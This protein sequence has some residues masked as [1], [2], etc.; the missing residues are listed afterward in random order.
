MEPKERLVTVARFSDAI[1]AQLTKGGLEAEGIQCSLADLAPD[2]PGFEIELQVRESDVGRA[3]KI[4]SERLGEEEL[5]GLPSPAYSRRYRTYA[6]V[7]LVLSAIL[8]L[9]VLFVFLKDL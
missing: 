8:V 3:Q 5:H 6:L 2:S 1:T 7:T 9:M 4:L